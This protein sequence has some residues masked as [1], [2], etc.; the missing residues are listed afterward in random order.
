ML[1]AGG[2]YIM[3]P[4]RNLFSGVLAKTTFEEK[5]IAGLASLKW[6]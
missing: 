4:G 6:H 2:I 1:V 3:P 5:E